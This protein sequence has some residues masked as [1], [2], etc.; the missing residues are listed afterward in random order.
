MINHHLFV[1]L[2]LV[3]EVTTTTTTRQQSPEARDVEIIIIRGYFE[4]NINYGMRYTG[5][6]IAS[7]SN[8]NPDCLCHLQRDEEISIHVHYNIQHQIHAILTKNF[9]TM[10]IG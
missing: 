4:Q 7:P 5:Y 1:V 10:W 8:E 6:V 3:L 9:N 2:I